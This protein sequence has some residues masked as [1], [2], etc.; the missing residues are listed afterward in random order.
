VAEAA[1]DDDEEQ[2]ASESDSD[3]ELQL[4]VTV[5]EQ[6]CHVNPNAR[7]LAEM[8]LRIKVGG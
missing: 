1:A 6:A 7:G 2:V 5:T 8:L 3:I 4:Y